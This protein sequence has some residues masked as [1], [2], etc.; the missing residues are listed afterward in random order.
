MRLPNIGD[1]YISHFIRG[2][3]DGDGCVYFGK[4]IRKDTE[5]Y[6]CV[7]KTL[8]TSGSRPFLSSLHL[9]LKQK[10][11][12]GGHISEKRKSGY[13][14]VLSHTDSLALYRLMYHTAPISSLYL[15]R[16]REKIERAIQ[17]LGLG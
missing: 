8:F 7:F 1:E 15:P 5:T 14:L 2:Y 12:A 6:R 4:H 17:V 11:I 10:G 13:D 9:V 16:K 3:F